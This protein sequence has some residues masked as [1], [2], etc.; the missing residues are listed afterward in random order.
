MSHQT[1]FLQQSYLDCTEQYIQ[2]LQKPNLPLW[3]YII[4]TASNESQ[5]ES[6]R[7]Q[8]AYRLRKG[9][10][11]PGSHYA[12]LPDPDGQRVG[13]G[14]A[15]LHVLR[16]V[17]EREGSF[18]GKRILVIHSGGDSKRIPQYSAC[19]KLFS[20]VPRLLPNGRRSTLFD[21]FMIACG[22]VAARIS[23]G[24]LVC[25]GDVLLLFNPL[26]IDFYGKGAAALSIKEPAEV[27]RNHGVFRVDGEGNVGQFLHKKTVDQLEGLGAVDG[28]GHVDIDTG[29]V[30]LD[31]AMLADLYGLVDTPEKF[32]AYVNGKAR[33]SF[34]GDFL[35]PLASAA[36]L[37]EYYQETPEGD[38]TP[39][40]HACRTALWQVLH[41][42]RM[43][44]IRMSPAAFIHFGTTRELRHLMTD[45]LEAYRYLG[46]QAW[47]QTNR[48]KG[49]PESASRPAPY[50]AR[51]CGALRYAVSNSYISPR[52]VVAEGCYIEDSYI[53]GDTVVG[54]GCVISGV[55][56]NGQ[57]VPKEAVL[58]GLKLKDGR[59]VA[60]MY[61]VTDNPKEITLFGRKLKEPLWT[62]PVYPVGNTMEE[63]V[64]AV[65]AAYD[66]G[67]PENDTCVSLRDSFEQ[68]DVT[69]ILP[70]QDKLEDKVRAEF[71][72]EAVD[73]REDVREVLHA[74]G[75]EVSDRVVRLLVQEAERLDQGK[76][77]E[78]GR[79]IRIY[80][81]L[82]CLEEGSRE[83]EE[84]WVQVKECATD[85]IAGTVWEGTRGKETGYAVGAPLGQTGEQAEKYLDACFHTISD[86][87]LTAAVDNLKDDSWGQTEM[88]K[89]E[90]LVRLPVRVNWG[91][92]WSDTPPYC[93]EHG[94]TV[95]NAAVLL[96]GNCP[97]EAVARQMKG[98][99]IVLASD[100][101]GARQEFTDVARLQDSSN[102]YDPY[103]LHKAALIA[104]G[105]IPYREVVAMEEITGK[106]GGGLYLSTQVVNI[107]RGSG[108]GTSSILA[109]A[110]VKALYE[111]LGRELS[112]EEL[113]QRVLCMEQLMSTGGGWQDQVGGLTPGIKMITSKAG[114]RQKISCTHCRISLETMEELER[115]FCLIYSGQRRL[116]RNLLRDVVGRYV[117]GVREAVDVLYEI[118]RLA[119]LM[120]FEL[121]KGNVDGFAGLLSEHWELSK[122]LDEGCTN[123]CIDMIFHAVE[124]LV[125]GRMICGAGGGGFLQ[126]VLKRGVT[127]EQMQARLRE[128][129][130]DSGV[131]V[132]KCSFQF[133]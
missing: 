116:A 133:P 95:L 129:F 15:T 97:V 108:L 88:K 3:D 38:F 130:R 50:H 125:C 47:I 57:K 58:H 110:C 123:T 27:G 71:L 83:A 72:L 77:E 93:M 109:G 82:S 1:L 34:Y 28:Q 39:E 2:I 74:M 18:A 115:R 10:L 79:K 14:G 69:A 35:Y 11:P 84:P 128:V 102:P 44:L 17:H 62:A 6:Y 26:Q 5:A 36:T 85:K 16:Y 103:A 4:L 113:Y 104:C 118:Q 55:T 8:I 41:P 101:S 29:A 51:G 12:V 21:E 48:G 60:R 25:S 31:S 54:R 78:F 43:K 94:G 112:E 75:G 46:W 119:V 64:L 52:A 132:W 107:P 23:G 13:S 22:G 53:H 68:A 87:I 37:E 73:R 56:L 33:L 80:Y 120:R 67:F 70:W 9:M 89:Q 63:A 114:I 122:K 59:F 98:N 24:M 124:D 40:L 32:A 91:G 61:A 131:E 127:V 117:G 96:D 30:I 92:G 111:I 19:G 106:L 126:V 42:Y 65:L 99:R 100:D 7:M 45:G 49:D 76:L 66:R 121:E 90:V 86:A 81:M 105:I 20:P